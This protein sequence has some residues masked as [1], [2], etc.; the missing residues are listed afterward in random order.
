MLNVMA[1][2][3]LWASA[4]P[5]VFVELWERTHLSKTSCHKIIFVKFGKVVQVMTDVNEILR[6][7]T[8]FQIWKSF[9]FEL[10][11]LLSRSANI[12]T[13][14][15]Y[16]KFIRIGS[17]TK[18]ASIFVNFLNFRLSSQAWLPSISTQSCESRT[19]KCETYLC[20]ITFDNLQMVWTQ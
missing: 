1:F 8:K 7:Y 4:T 6:L 19:F 3:Q 5:N 13:S 9:N 17:P 16:C 10:R 14:T 15:Y 12:Y 11:S 20:K 18:M 2:G